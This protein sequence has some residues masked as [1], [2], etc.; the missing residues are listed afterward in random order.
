MKLNEIKQELTGEY[1]L[2]EG[3]IPVHLTMMLD[4]VIADGQISNRVQ[5]FI[6]AGLVGMFKDGGPYRWPRDLNAYP[7]STSSDMVEAIEHL[8]PAEA[9]EL[10]QWL[11]DSL[12]NP[13]GFESNPRCVNSP[14]DPVEWMRWVLKKQ[15]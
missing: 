13:A 2:S 10:T 8:T 7:M 5:H 11:I 15:D 4:Q 9:V 1:N 14:L 12:K 3:V 6:I